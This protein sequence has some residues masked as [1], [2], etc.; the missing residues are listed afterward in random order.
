MAERQETADCEL[1]TKKEVARKFGV[2]V[3]TIERYL[4]L[5]QLPVPIRLPRGHLRWWRKDIDEYLERLRALRPTVGPLARGRRP[6]RR[7]SPL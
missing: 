4:A 5:N 6:P 2:C 3:R 7:K 1:L